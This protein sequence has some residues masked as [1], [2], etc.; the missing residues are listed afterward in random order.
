VRKKG[1]QNTLAKQQRQQEE[2]KYPVSIDAN[3][4][5]S[6]YRKTLLNLS[7]EER[8]ELNDLSTIL[9]LS[10]DEE[11]YL[12]SIWRTSIVQTTSRNSLSVSRKKGSRGTVG[13]YTVPMREVERE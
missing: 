9:N 6:S 4:S 10:R 7:R 8:N 11:T 3:V 2:E 1:E 13:D 12:I 5:S